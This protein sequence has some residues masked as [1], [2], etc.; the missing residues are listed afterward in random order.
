MVTGSVAATSGLISSRWIASGADSYLLPYI[1]LQSF[2]LVFVLLN[3]SIMSCCC[4]GSGRLGALC[5]LKV[6]LLAAKKV[7]HTEVV[8]KGEGEGGGG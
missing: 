8:E 2:D 3:E 5:F 1:C 6:S 7:S 4:V